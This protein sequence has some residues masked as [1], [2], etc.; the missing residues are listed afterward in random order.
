MSTSRVHAQLRAEIP[1]CP[2]TDVPSASFYQL[3]L[4]GTRCVLKS[5]SN[6]NQ[7]Y[8]IDLQIT[9]QYHLTEI[10]EKP[11][12]TTRHLLYAL[13]DHYDENHDRISRVRSTNKRKDLL[14]R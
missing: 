1:R 11:V 6:S 4:S 14:D 7:S 13:L 2:Y 3:H 9:R 10:T 8:H 5:P 12:C